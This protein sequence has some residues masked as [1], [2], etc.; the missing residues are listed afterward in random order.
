MKRNDLCVIIMVGLSGS[1]KS[2]WARDYCRKHENWVVV[3]R[4]AFRYMLK[5]SPVT[6]PKTESMINELV[7][8]TIMKSLKYKCN[9]IVDNT[10]VRAHRINEITELVKYTA[11]VKFMVFDLPAKKC[12]EN[13]SKRDR[14]VG[15]AVIRAQ[16]ED[17]K[18]LKDSFVFQDL[19]K[20]PTWQIPRSIPD[21]NTSLPNAVIFDIDGTLAFMNNREPY[22]WEKVDRDNP[23]EIVIQQTKFYRDLGYKIIIVTGRER[24]CY[25]QT[26]EWLEFYGIK[27][28]HFFMRDDNDGRKDAAFKKEVYLNEIKD[29][30]NV[31]CIFDD[32]KQVVDKWRELGLFVF[33]CNQIGHEF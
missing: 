11:D 10:H 20:K 16:D 18:I 17:F 4:D 26:M 22:D 6:D 19:K 27:F 9:V 30:F 12:I 5:N 25:Q 21:F 15:E 32:R 23:N 8:H 14:K 2:T 7:E 29:K 3:S 24:I 31:I 33:D 28:D 13:D 1:G